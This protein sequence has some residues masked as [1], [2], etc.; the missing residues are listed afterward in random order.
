MQD[1]H[2]GFLDRNT[3]NGIINKAIQGTIS[4]EEA[5]LI[6]VEC[7]DVVKYDHWVS[8]V[9]DCTY[10]KRFSMLETMIKLAKSE[11]LLVIDTATVMNFDEANM[12]YKD[13]LS[14]GEEGAVLKNLDGIWKDHTSPNQVKMKVK[15]PADLLCVGTQPH[16]KKPD[17]IGALILESS[18]GIIKVSSGS[19]LTDD[20][21]QKSPDFFIGKI[22]EVEYNEISEDKKT[23]QKSLFLPIYIDVREDK[24]EADS[25]ETILERSSVK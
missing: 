1:G 18:D 22:I 3:G 2:G 8:G 5:A 10:D 16:S 15:D 17:W 23:G 25:Y 21:R 14:K 4:K 11:K 19:G 20:L 24:S 12:F 13:M 7:W 6:A 9:S